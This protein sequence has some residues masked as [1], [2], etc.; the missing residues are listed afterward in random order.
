MNNEL[1]TSKREKRFSMIV[2]IK[3]I[4]F[5]RLLFLFIFFVMMI[6]SCKKKPIQYSACKNCVYYPLCDGKRYTYEKITNSGTVELKDTFRYIKDTVVNNITF[7]KFQISFTNGIQ[8]SYFYCNGG[9]VKELSF[10]TILTTLNSNL[11]INGQWIDTVVQSSGIID[12]YKSTI[13]GKNISRTVNSNN[14]SD[15]IHVLLEGSRFYPGMG[16]TTLDNID[17]Y[18]ANGIGLIERK[19]SNPFLGTVSELIKIKD[20][21]IP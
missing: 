5:M 9:I 13:M 4:F 16:N 1:R 6:F 10:N 18:Y 17:S 14:F 7:K 19:Y 2:I 12:I 3:K 20:Y 21:N 11:P 15:V 8:I